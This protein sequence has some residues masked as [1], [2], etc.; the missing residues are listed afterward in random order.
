MIHE[1]DVFRPRLCSQLKFLLHFFFRLFC[2]QHI[3][4]YAAESV[5]QGGSG[6]RE[7]GEWQHSSCVILPKVTVVPLLP[8]LPRRLDQ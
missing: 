3:G 2:R 4:Q 8:P 7:G 5:Q 1:C 6:Q